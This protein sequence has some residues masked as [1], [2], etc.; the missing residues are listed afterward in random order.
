MIR[1]YF[2]EKIGKE[3][4]H[5]K[6]C[7]QYPM[8][9]LTALGVKPCYDDW[10]SMAKLPAFVEMCSRYGLHV[11]KDIVFSWPP[12]REDVIGKESITTTFFKGIRPQDADEGECHIFVSKRK[13]VA[14]EAKKAGW[15]P[16]VVVSGRTINKPFIDHLRFGLLLGYPACCVDFFRRYN[17]WNRFSHPYETKKNT[18]EYSW[19]CNNFLMDYTFFLIHN[20]PCSYDCQATIELARLA[21]KRLMEEEPRFI[22]ETRE[23][24]HKPLLV[25]GERNFILFDGVLEGN[26]IRYRNYQYISNPARQEDIFGH[27]RDIDAGDSVALGDTLDILS[28]GK[29]LKSI[30]GKKEW[31]LVAFR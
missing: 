29:V 28:G 19:Y 20:L 3:Y 10:V 27:M 24:L 15:Y 6:G 31:F 13:D 2:P 25:F 14:L 16:G 18:R 8:F 9:A 11:E 1:N 7:G 17:D 23:M 4:V 12:P 21:E 30:P 26:R 5:I 22:A